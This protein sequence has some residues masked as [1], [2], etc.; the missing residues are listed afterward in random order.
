MAEDNFQKV[1]VM[2][3][4]AD[5]LQQEIHLRYGRFLQFHQKS[6][7]K[8]ITHYLKGL[9]V[10]EMSYARENL[11]KALEKVVEKRLERNVRV[12]ESLILLGLIHKLRGEV[13]EALLCYERL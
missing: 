8:A 5:H 10:K 4:I 12:V 7:D 9:K 3:N 11:L 13:N 1:L 2:E 6:E